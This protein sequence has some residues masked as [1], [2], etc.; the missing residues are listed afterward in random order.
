MSTKSAR[1]SSFSKYAWGEGRGHLDIS[2]SSPGGASWGR[3][4]EGDPEE[5]ISHCLGPGGPL[6][7]RRPPS[8]GL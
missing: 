6:R 3:G 1:S 2:A 5:V 8:A 7:R 4:R